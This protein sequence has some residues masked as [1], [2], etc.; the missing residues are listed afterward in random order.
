MIKNLGMPISVD[1]FTDF[2]RNIDFL[3]MFEFVVGVEVI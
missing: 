3:T 1:Q 2:E